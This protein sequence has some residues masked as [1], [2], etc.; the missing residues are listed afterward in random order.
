MNK[1]RK[2]LTTGLGLG[3]APF[4]PGTFGSAG[5]VAVY[6]LAVLALPTRYCVLGV[7]SLVAMFFS[8]VCV[9]LGPFTEKAFGKKDPS[10]CTADEWAGQAVTMLALPMVGAGAWITCLVGFGAFRLFDITKPPPVRQ[11]EKLP[12]GWGVLVDDLAA[13]VYANITAQL[14]LRLWI[15]S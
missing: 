6:A 7:M 13:G 8:V 12:Q 5:A 14:V 1:L 15:V 10:H 9:K 3:Y 2:F 11:L 4:A